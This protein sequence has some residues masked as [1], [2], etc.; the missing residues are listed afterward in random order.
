MES[1]LE[2]AKKRRDVAYVLIVLPKC[3]AET[4]LQGDNESR[5][6]SWKTVVGLGP[7]QKGCSASR[8]SPGNHLGGRGEH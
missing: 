8:I 2:D 7:R 3:C 5:E 4:R 1:P 6:T